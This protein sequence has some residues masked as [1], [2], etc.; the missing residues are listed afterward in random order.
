[1][2]LENVD[3]LS[4]PHF[5]IINGPNDC[6][7]CGKSDAQKEYH[8]AQRI[9]VGYRMYRRNTQGPTGTV[10][11]SPDFTEAVRLK[12]KATERSCR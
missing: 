7:R 11:K 6:A 9:A 12:E 1:M 3:T 10:W 5:V 2:N 4:V 8:Q